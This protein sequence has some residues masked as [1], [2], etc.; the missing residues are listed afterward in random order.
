MR[1]II[2]SIGSIAYLSRRLLWFFIS[3]DA[4]NAVD[5][6]ISVVSS[7]VGVNQPTELGSGPG[8]EGITN[9]SAG[10]ENIEVL[11]CYVRRKKFSA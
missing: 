5:G 7:A 9:S 4:G 11:K 10:K 3:L 8:F 1:L 6:D 2:A